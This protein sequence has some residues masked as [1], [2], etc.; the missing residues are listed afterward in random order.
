MGN[1]C[2]T[3]IVCSRT[4]GFEDSCRYALRVRWLQ[5]RR[6]WVFGSQA[7]YRHVRVEW[8]VNICYLMC[9]CQCHVSVSFKC[10]AP[11]KSSFRLCLLSVITALNLKNVFLVNNLLY[12]RK[13][14]LSFNTNLKFYFILWYCTT[15]LCGPFVGIFSFNSSKNVGHIW[16]IIS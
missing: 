15:A 1:F 3:E 11:R 5:Q 7:F 4:I 14:T 10:G 8:V 9:Q 2:A 16:L 13:N 6:K 12:F